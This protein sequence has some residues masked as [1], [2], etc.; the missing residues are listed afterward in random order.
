MGSI[1]KLDVKVK[2]GGFV[3]DS[4]VADESGEPI[5]E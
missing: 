3:Y 2:H 5:L 4:W 1:H